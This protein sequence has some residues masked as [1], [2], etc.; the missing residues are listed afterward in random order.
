MDHKRNL[1][2]V[3]YLAKSHLSLGLKKTIHSLDKNVIMAKTTGVHMTGSA[4]IKQKLQKLAIQI[5]R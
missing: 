3:E 1:K 5:V 4:A 2:H